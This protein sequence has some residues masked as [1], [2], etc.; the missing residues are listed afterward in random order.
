MINDHHFFLTSSQKLSQICSL[1]LNRMDISYFAF[2]RTYIDGSFIRLSTNPLWS[3]SYLHNRYFELI[4]IDKTILIPDKY[5]HHCWHLYP[6]YDLESRTVMQDAYQNFNLKNGFAIVKGQ[7][8]CTDQFIIADHK[9]S[10]IYKYFS[11][12]QDINDFI[13]LF[14]SNAHSIIEQ[15]YN[16]RFT[17]K[18]LI[19]S[20]LKPSLLKT[21]FNRRETECLHFLSQGKTYKERIFSPGSKI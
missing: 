2:H 7:K 5:E 11:Q 9:E 8:Q 12:I 4:K 19:Q 18:N 21:K 3:K 16:Y 20:T 10:S 15:A 13:P 1:L 17:I 14:L 6:Q